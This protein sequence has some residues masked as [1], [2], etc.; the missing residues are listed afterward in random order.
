MREI[1]ECSKLWRWLEGIVRSGSKGWWC[2]GPMKSSMEIEA[3]EANMM[4]M[5]SRYLDFEVGNH[6]GAV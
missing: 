1:E 2:S 6:G 5:S 4:R 3:V